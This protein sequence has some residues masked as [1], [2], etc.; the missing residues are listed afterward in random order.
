MAALEIDSGADQPDMAE[1]LEEAAE[2]LAA[3]RVDLLWQ[4]PRVVGVAEEPPKQCGG[5][6][7]LA[8]EGEVV[9]PPEVG[10]RPP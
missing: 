1:G 10:V 2:Q 9:D 5:P 7:G 4:Q 3:C 6:V 8:V